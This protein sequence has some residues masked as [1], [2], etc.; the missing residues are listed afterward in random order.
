MDEENVNKIIEILIESLQEIKI[1]NGLLKRLISLSEHPLEKFSIKDEEIIDFLSKNSFID[2][3]KF[4]ELYGVT[5]PTAIKKM[6]DVVKRN[7][8][9]MRYI[10]GKAPIQPDRIIFIKKPN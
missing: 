6:K 10:H 2:T 5:K 1:S 9:C 4:C 7:P 3:N 8:D